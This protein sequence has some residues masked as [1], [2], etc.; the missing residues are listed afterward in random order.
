MR[1]YIDHLK[2]KT[3][4]TKQMTP[5]QYEEEQLILQYLTIEQALFNAIQHHQN[6]KELLEFHQQKLH[7]FPFLSEYSAGNVELKSLQRQ[8][9]E[10]TQHLHEVQSNILEDLR[11]GGWDFIKDSKDG[12]TLMQ[13]LYLQ[14]YGDE[15]GI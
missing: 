14:N 11:N 7:S 13:C 8:F 1:F 5:E 2:P 4:K 9:H 6:K 10:A 3:G 12:F 15:D